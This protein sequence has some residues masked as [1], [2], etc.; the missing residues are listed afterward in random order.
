MLGFK[1]SYLCRSEGALWSSPPL[2]SLH[3]ELLQSVRAILKKKKFPFC[4][5]LPRVNLKE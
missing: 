1:A 5:L 4:L 2:F 3:P